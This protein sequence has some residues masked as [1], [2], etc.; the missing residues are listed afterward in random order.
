VRTSRLSG[1]YLSVWRYDAAGKWV[2]GG[3]ADSHVPTLEVPDLDCVVL[4]S[5]NGLA[6]IGGDTHGSNPVEMSLQRSYLLTAFKVPDFKGPTRRGDS[7]TAIR[8]CA[9]GIDRAGMCPR[10]V[11]PGAPWE[12][13]NRDRASCSRNGRITIPGPNGAFVHVTAPLCGAG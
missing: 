7:L 10:W 6:A 9:Y 4:R 3:E 13:G 11:P 1:N 2:I 8:R 5:G 12:T